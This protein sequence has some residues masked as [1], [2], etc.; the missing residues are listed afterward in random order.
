M[1]RL[2]ILTK[3]RAGRAI[4]LGAERMTIGRAGDNAFQIS[5][6]A[7]STYHCEVTMSGKD[8][9]V[10]DLGSTNGTFIGGEKITS[11][12]VRPGQRLR[13]GD[14]ELR[15]ETRAKV[16]MRTRLARLKISVMALISWG[17]TRFSRVSS[18]FTIERMRKKPRFAA[19]V[20]V[21]ILA[22]FTGVALASHFLGPPG[23][24]GRWEFTETSG[25]VA[26]DSGGKH[27]GRLIDA[28][29]WTRGIKGGAVRFEGARAQ[30]VY[31]G[32]ILQGSYNGITI[33]CWVR[34]SRSTWQTVVERSVWNRSD[35]IGLCM[36]NNGS[37][38]DF[39]HYGRGDYVRS[40]T[41]VQD[42]QW[43]HIAG[44][45]SK[46]GGNYIY[47]IY[48]DG[49]LDN[50]ITNSMG[51]PATSGAWAIGA[52]SN[53]GWPYKGLIGDVRIFD[54]ALSPSEIRK[55]YNQ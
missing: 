55:I 30:A 23:Q 4:E 22:V 54:R 11:G 36:D 27:N 29:K 12:I 17:A 31:L 7:V 25:T 44:T 38:V 43:H 28:P 49:K 32:N 42:G 41:D 14:V 15:F 39:G 3:G 2:V 52:R 47:R 8:L 46:S 9:V 19:A 48:V 45:M 21:S 13:L 1:A 26:K 34:H 35:G 18:K 16:P 20:F 50:S 37:G 6:P 51:L 24:V 33:A 5:D 53:G 10:K 40:K